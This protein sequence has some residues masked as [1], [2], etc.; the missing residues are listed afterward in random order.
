MYGWLQMQGQGCHSQSATA[1]KAPPLNG[2]HPTTLWDPKTARECGQTSG[3]MLY[4]LDLEAGSI[5]PTQQ[6]TVIKQ[7]KFLR[8]FVEGGGG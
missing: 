1:K 6:G 4:R 2:G 5:H 3:F 8:G 7:D